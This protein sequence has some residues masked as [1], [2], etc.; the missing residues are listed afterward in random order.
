M[1]KNA[2]MTLNIKFEKQL[3]EQKKQQNE[4]IGKKE[5]AAT[6]YHRISNLF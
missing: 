2:K 3:V 1:P 4:N 6:T 5:L